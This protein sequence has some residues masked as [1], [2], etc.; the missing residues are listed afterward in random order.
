MGKEAEIFYTNIFYSKVKISKK[1][2]KMI[3]VFTY[4][5]D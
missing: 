4:C 2:E 1:K 5:Y 3:S